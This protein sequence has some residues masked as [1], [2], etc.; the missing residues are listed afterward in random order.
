MSKDPAF[1]FYSKDWIEGTAEMLPEEKGIFIDLLAHQHQSG[2]LPTDTKRLARIARV[3]HD[4]FLTIWNGGL[5]VKFQSTEDRLINKKLSSVMSKRSSDAIVKRIN[6]TLAG[7]YRK[8]KIDETKKAQ[9]RELFNIDEF[10][11]VKTEDLTIRL[12]TWLVNSLSSLE[13]GNAIENGI[14]EDNTQ[15]DF[16]KSENLLKIPIP[17]NVLEAAE[18]NQYDFTKNRNTEFIKSQWQ[19]FL[20]ERVHDPPTKRKAYESDHSQLFQYFLNWIRNKFPKD[21]TTKRNGAHKPG[22]GLSTPEPEIKSSRG[23]SAL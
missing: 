3:S 12:T 22:N 23:F 1:L 13:I 4:E 2:S 17:P 21:G 10:L 20:K 16:G 7:L 18:M 9:L 19:I 14:K 11:N 8:H 6:G 15:K 5:S